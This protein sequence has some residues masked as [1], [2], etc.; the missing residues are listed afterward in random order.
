MGL[1]MS[2]AISDVY[3][4]EE[5]RSVTIA[6]VKLVSAIAGIG[7][8]ICTWV[9]QAAKYPDRSEF[10]GLAADVRALDDKLVTRAESIAQDQQLL[11]AKIAVLESTVAHLDYTV[12]A[13]LTRDHNASLAGGRK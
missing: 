9:W 1:T 5:K 12:R 3:R 13:V 7:L 2:K 10:L 11:L 8:L 6:D 4:G